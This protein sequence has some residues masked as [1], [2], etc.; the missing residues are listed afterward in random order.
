MLT[1]T[2]TLTLNQPR[3]HK[4]VHC[5]HR[6]IVLYMEGLILGAIIYLYTHF[7]CIW[8]AWKELI[9]VCQRAEPY[10]AECCSGLNTQED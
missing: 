7:A 10:I 2:D 9:T 1:A 5:L 8:V 4:C 3:T 6:P